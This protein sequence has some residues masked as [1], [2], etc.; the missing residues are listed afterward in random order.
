[1][2]KETIKNKNALDSQELLTMLGQKDVDIRILIKRV[3][4]LEALL[5]KKESNNV[6]SDNDRRPSKVR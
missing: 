6:K 3:N 5:K 4:E 2:G 1:M